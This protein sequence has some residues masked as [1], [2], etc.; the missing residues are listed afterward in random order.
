MGVG[1]GLEGSERALFANRILLEGED[2]IRGVGWGKGCWLVDIAEAPYT[3]VVADGS[4][5]CSGWSSV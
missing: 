5:R 2:G 3:F 4:N 1:D